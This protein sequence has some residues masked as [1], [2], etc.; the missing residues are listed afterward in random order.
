MTDIVIFLFLYILRIYVITLEFM[1]CSA[2][3]DSM[4]IDWVKYQLITLT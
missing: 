4:S 2:V 3:K 1:L